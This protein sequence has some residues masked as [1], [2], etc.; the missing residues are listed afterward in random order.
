M[1]SK[2]AL[3]SLTNSTSWHSSEH[4]IS[5]LSDQEADGKLGS[6]WNISI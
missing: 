3:V 6:M 1:L 2:A 4:N 5:G